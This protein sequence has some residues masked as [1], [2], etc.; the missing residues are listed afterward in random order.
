MRHKYV[1]EEI[2]SKG[3]QLLHGGRL[4]GDNFHGSSCAL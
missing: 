1:Q 2:Q 4:N 3:G